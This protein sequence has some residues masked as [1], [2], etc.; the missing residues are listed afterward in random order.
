MSVDNVELTAAAGGFPE[1]KDNMCEECVKEE[2]EET[3]V[4]P[5][6]IESVTTVMGSEFSADSE[7]ENPSQTASMAWMDALTEMELLSLFTLD[8]VPFLASVLAVSSW[9]TLAKGQTDRSS[10]ASFGEYR[11]RVGGN[12]PPVVRQY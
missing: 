9:S 11:I 7:P 10:G 5:G 12:A 3:T 4:P 2:K 1:S 6:S 8:D